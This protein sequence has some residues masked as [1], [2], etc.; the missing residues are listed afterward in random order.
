MSFRDRF[1]FVQNII[2]PQIDSI[3]RDDAR[4]VSQIAET[5]IPSGR[6]LKYLP[7]LFSQDERRLIGVLVLV[8]GLCVF[9]LML[10]WYVGNSGRPVSGGEYHEGVIGYPQLINPILSQPGSVDAA[11]SSL[12]YRKLFQ[13][14][15]RVSITPDLVDS[16]EVDDSGKRYTIRLKHDILWDDGESLSSDDVVFTFSLIQDPETR[17]PLYRRFAGVTVEAEDDATVVFTLPEAYALFPSLL[18]VGILPQHIWFSSAGA[19]VSLSVVNQKPIGNGMFRFHRFGKN[20]SGAITFYEFNRNPL[21]KGDAS[22]LDQLRF[23]FFPDQASVKTA[24]ANGSIDGFVPIN[25]AD[26]DLG[27]YARSKGVDIQLVKEP[28]VV[29]LGFNTK[30]DLWQNRDIRKSFSALFD[31]AQIVEQATHGFGYE[32][33]SLFDLNPAFATSTAVQRPGITDFTQA[34][35]K[36]GWKLEGGNWRNSKGGF[37]ASVV[38]PD[39]PELRAVAQTMEAQLSGTGVVLKVEFVEPSQ[40][41]ERLRGRG[42]DSVLMPIDVGWNQDLYQLLHSSQAP[43]AGLNAPLYANRESDL[44]IQKIRT[45]VSEQDRFTA[46]ESLRKIAANDSPWFALFGRGIPFVHRSRLR[47]VPGVVNARPEDRFITVNHWYVNVR[48][49]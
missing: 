22:Y 20:D 21:Y 36:A 15:E 13:W 12:V 17:S 26:Q 45:S 39:I 23:S 7:A 6:Q 41:R 29:L 19:R 32:V 16:Y 5:R 4:L 3:Q 18:T 14:D 31:T 46:F 27:E 40:F 11:L 38:A 34:M 49:W 42:Y 47:G 24:F 2:H 37:E 44:A 35:E 28:E 33:G 8:V 25:L 48:R 43:I 30:A 9:G 10:I 1:R